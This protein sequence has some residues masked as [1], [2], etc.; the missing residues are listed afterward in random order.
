[1]KKIFYILSATLIIFS[2]IKIQAQTLDEILTKYF[3]TIGQDKLTQVQSIIV[4][5]KL[6]QGNIEIPVM[7]YSKRPNKTRM[8]GTFQGLTFISAY[9]GE[10]GWHLNPFMGDTLP[11]QATDEELEELKEQADIDGMLYNYK[12]KGYTL[13]LAGTEDFEGQQVYLLKLTKPNG[14]VYTHYID[15]ENYVTLKT[16]AKI[17]SKGVE[18]E[19]ETDFSNYKPVEGVI[20]P[21]NIETKVG[22]N[23]V[24]QF[25]FDSFTFNQDIDD[26]IFEMSSVS[27]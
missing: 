7:G 21:F 22:G 19:V 12:E 10:T 18:Q 20:F 9:N 6:I 26:S 14:N 3:E 24:A 2:C 17:K 16:V 23:T 4:K 5:G 25:V 8:E 13:D 11:Q 15:A 27:K 1:M